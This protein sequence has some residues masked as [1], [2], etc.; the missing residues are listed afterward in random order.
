MTF[1]AALLIFFATPTNAGVV[2]SYLGLLAHHRSGAAGL[3]IMEIPLFVNL[4]ERGHFMVGLFEAFMSEV[5]HEFHDALIVT[6]LA[7]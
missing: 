3:A 5:G 7:F 2:S 4:L 1:E 6:L